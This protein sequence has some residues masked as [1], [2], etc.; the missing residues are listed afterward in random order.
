MFDSQDVKLL[1]KSFKAAVGCERGSSESVKSPRGGE[2][3][4]PVRAGMC[5]VGGLFGFRV[6]KVFLSVAVLEAGENSSRSS[7]RGFFPNHQQPN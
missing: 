7:L 3:V 6:R 2:G 1:L 5:G 4:T